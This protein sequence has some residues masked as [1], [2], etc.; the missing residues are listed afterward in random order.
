MCPDNEHSFEYLPACP[1]VK[2]VNIKGK[3]GML[4]S[5]LLV[6]ESREWMDQL[7]NI[8]QGH[9]LILDGIYLGYWLDGSV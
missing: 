3:K 1:G 7:R 2:S 5:S 9:S 6:I 8:C 4:K